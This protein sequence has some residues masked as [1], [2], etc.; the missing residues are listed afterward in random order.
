MSTQRDS[1]AEKNIADNIEDLKS[2]ISLAGTTK[3]A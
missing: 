2:Q 1:G 3:F